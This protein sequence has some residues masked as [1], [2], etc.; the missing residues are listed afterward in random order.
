MEQ[1]GNSAGDCVQKQLVLDDVKNDELK[2]I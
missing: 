1:W 2:I